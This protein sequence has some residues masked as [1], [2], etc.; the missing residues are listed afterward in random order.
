MANSQARQRVA[1]AGTITNTTT[2][3]V[4]PQVL[5]RIAQG[6]EAFVALLMTSVEATLDHLPHLRAN[7][8]HLLA[9]RP[10]TADTLRTAQIILDSFERSHLLTTPRHDQTI[11]GGDGHYCFFDLPPGNY[12]LTATMATLDHCYGAIRGQVQVQHTDHWLAF[13]ELDMALTLVPSHLPLPSSEPVK[14][15]E[16]RLAEAMGLTLR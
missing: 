15:Q 2:G 11:T 5:V 8:N 6:P 3:E 10:I 14:S 13:S 7:Y 4:M 12:G 9:G 1:I 16:A